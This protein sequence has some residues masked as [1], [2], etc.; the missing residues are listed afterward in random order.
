MKKQNRVAFFN[1]LSVV[2]LRGISFFTGPIFSRMLGT[3]SYGVTSIYNIWVSAVAIVFSLQVAGTLPT[4]RVQFP[5]EK[6]DG[7]HSSILSM[8][9]ASFLTLSL[10][11]MIFCRPIAS[12]LH[13]DTILVPLLLMHAFCNFCAQ[14]LNQK[15]VYEYRADLNCLI[16]VLVAVLTLVLSIV[17]IKLLPPEQGYFGRIFAVALTYGVVGISG[18]IYILR[19]GRVFYN[20]EYWK[21]CLPLALPMVFYTLSDLVLGQSDRVMLQNMMNDSAVGQY[22]YALNFAMIMFT[23]FTA[24]NTSWCPFFFDDMKYGRKENVIRQGR[25]FA[26]LF[27]VLSAG[28]VLLCREVFR[29]YA[30]ADYWPAMS[31]IPVFVAGYYLNFLCTF[32]INYEYYRQKTKAVAVITVI[33]SIVNIG[34]NF[35]LIQQM[36]MLGAAV[37]TTVSHCL[38]FALHYGY[39]R[40][41][42]GDYPFP[43]KTWLVPG[44]MF[45]AVVVLALT[46]EKLWLLRWGLGA[47]IGIWELVRIKK[48]K[49]LF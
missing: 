12:A 5:E 45:L 32:P 31:C 15:F 33:V 47:A 27:T 7:Y 35:L 30:R 3:G 9:M 36:G 26:E 19:R 22:S 43:V 46:G 38:Q 48:R 21:F 23:I 6:Q 28:F 49:S 17:F 13:F 37:A 42:L 11:V 39:V 41:C 4:A 10:V 8:A 18:C 16:S 40:L 29:V 34:L 24:L 2:L 14:L 44:L 1:F 25:H 20:R